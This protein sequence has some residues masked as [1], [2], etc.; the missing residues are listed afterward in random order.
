MAACLSLAAWSATMAVA[1]SPGA[2]PA[3]VAGQA[4]GDFY[5]QVPVPAPQPEKV[6]GQEKVPVVPVDPV[7]PPPVT[8][9]I[10]PAMPAGP[11]CCGGGMGGCCFPGRTPCCGDCSDCDG[12]CV[13]RFL[14]GLYHC[15]CC[16]DPCYEP[17]WIPAQNAAFFV[18]PVRP[19]T[20]TR[21]RADFGRNFTYPDIGEFFLVETAGHGRGP[22]TVGPLRANYDQFSLYQ[23]V[24][25]NKRFSLFFEFTGL[26]V[27][28]DGIGGG[29]FGDM[30][31]GTKSVL[32]DCELFLLAF[33]FRTYIPMGNAARLLGTGHVSLEPSLLGAIKVSANTYLQFQFAEWF[34]IAGDPDSAGPVFH[35]H[36]S[37]NQ[38]LYRI[39]P[40]VPLIGTL[41]INDYTYQGGAFTSAILAPTVAGGA[42]TALTTSAIGHSFASGGPGL[43]VSVCNKLDFGVAAM[44]GFDN[45][46]PRQL[47]RAEIRWRY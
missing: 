35:M 6:P 25:P 5:A 32:C 16:P 36:A 9:A 10:M 15:L 47:Y 8:G 42:A 11:G 4:L 12:S 45:G 28:S 26:H 13:H 27:Y 20:Q 19:W 21:L 41:E 43:R 23:E 33:Q 18:D 14:C 39:M 40:D 22:S 7:L 38:V 30:N 17:C 29:G 46:G 1:Q 44:F 37:L 2:A 24:A 31:L 3:P 34:P